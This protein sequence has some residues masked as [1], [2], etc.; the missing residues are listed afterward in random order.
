MEEKFRER[1]ALTTAE[2]G[3]QVDTAFRV[4]KLLLP[5]LLSTVARLFRTFPAKLGHL[6]TVLQSRIKM[7]R[8][9]PW[10]LE[11]K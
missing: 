2:Y 5:V 11:G 8:L 6:A 7:M 4:G 3:D 1:L 10:I 9:R